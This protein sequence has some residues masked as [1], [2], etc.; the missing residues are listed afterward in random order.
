MVLHKEAQTSPEHRR[1]EKKERNTLF[2]TTRKG[3]AIKTPRKSFY[4]PVV[5]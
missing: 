1:L 5:R 3:T 4:Y 2:V